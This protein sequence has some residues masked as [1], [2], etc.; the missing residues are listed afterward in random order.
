MIKIEYSYLFRSF[1]IM[2]LNKIDKFTCYVSKHPTEPLV[3]DVKVVDSC[4][5]GG[6]RLVRWRVTE[7]E[8]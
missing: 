1:H 7:N 3:S 6:G 8:Y 5:D 4:K 2:N